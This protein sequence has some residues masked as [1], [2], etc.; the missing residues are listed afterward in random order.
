M[1]GGWPSPSFPSRRYP[2]HRRR[3]NPGAHVGARGGHH[4]GRPPARHHR[5]V[6]GW[7]SSP[8]STARTTG[9]VFLSSPLPACWPCRRA[10]AAATRLL[11]D[12]IRQFGHKVLDDLRELWRRLVFSLLASNYDDHLRNHA[13][14]MLVPDRW[15]LSPAYDLNP[16]PRD[17]PRPDAQD[18]HF[19]GRGGTHH[20]RGARRCSAFWTQARRSQGDLGRGVCGGRSVAQ[21]RREAADQGRDVGRLHPARSSTP[22]MDEARHLLASRA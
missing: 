9:S 10:T 17:R 22:L 3:R 13:F 1:T 7:A 19:R 6:A 5:R 2:R 12:G 8:A 18:G 15:S 20:R 4:R 14:L 11:A 21:D 16:V